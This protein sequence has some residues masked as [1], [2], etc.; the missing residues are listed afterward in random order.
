MLKS[1]SSC[2]YC[3]IVII[4]TTNWQQWRS[5]KHGVCLKTVKMEINS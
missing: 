4:T 5:M 1:S 3:I 2:V